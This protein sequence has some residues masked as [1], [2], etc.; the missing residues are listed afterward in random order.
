MAGKPTSVQTNVTGGE[1]SPLAMGRFDLAKFPNSVKILENFLIY[2][3]GGGM[4]RPGTKYVAP[5]KYGD[6]RRTRLIKFQYSVLQNYAMEVGHEYIRF[7]SNG[8][9]VVLT[10]ADVT[11]WG[12]TTGYV[13]GDYVKE[14]GVIYYCISAHTSGTFATDLAANKWVAQSILEIPTPYTEDDIYLLQVAQHQDVMY[15]THPT[16]KVRKLTRN[17]A[18]DFALVEA[19]IV[20]GPFLDDNV[21]ATTIT[22]SSA[23]GATT[24]TASTS[25]FTAN[26]VGSFFRVKDGVVLITAYSSGTSVDGTVQAEPDGTAGNLGSTS[27]E[28]DWAEGAFSEKRG[29]PVTLAFHEQRMY[30][31]SEQYFYGSVIGQ[32][33]NFKE[34]ADDPSASVKFLIVAD[35]ANPI[36]WLASIAKSL[37]NGT[38]GGTFSASSGTANS[39]ITA[40][41]INA[42]QDTNYGVLPIKPAKIS[43]YL[44]YMQR[45][46]YQLRELVYDLLTDR[47]KAND[48]NLL[49]DHILRD[50]GGATDIKHQQSPNDRLWIPREDGQMAVLTRNPEQEV[51][52][53]SRI[54]AG[55]SS[56]VP[57]EFESV[58][59]L[60]ADRVDDV[61]WVIVRRKINGSWTKFVEYFTPE[62]FDDDFDAVHVDSSLTYDNP[63]NIT[64]ITLGASVTIGIVGH[65]LSNGAQ[66]RIDNILGRRPATGSGQTNVT[67]LNRKLFLVKNATADTF[68]LSDTS[69]GNISGTLYTAYL[70]GGEVREMITAV[71]GL[72]HLNGET[73]TVAVDGGLPSAQQTYEVV[74][75]AITLSQKA[76]VIHVGLPYTGTMQMLKLSDGAVPTGQMTKRRLHMSKFRV[77][78]SLGIKIGVSEETLGTV[79]FNK[80]NDP[81]G[82]P[83]ALVTGDVKKFFSGGWSEDDEVIIRQDQPLPLF[84]LAIVLKSEVE[85]S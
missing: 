69:G 38:A 34:D 42:N 81:L 30:Y 70:E 29:Y 18:I 72:D 15:I 35:E 85:E 74:A 45:N 19:P 11:A 14:A 3:L 55:E 22:A 10:L 21:T 51:L 65:G 62:K 61:V 41:D 47:S 43:S 5:T 20:R 12:T 64:S 4:F 8:A 73:V 53:W 63:L 37:Q 66:I 58:E 9:Q 6:L 68:Q 13:V 82:V 39:A 32:F 67:D 48:M 44:Y 50:G 56:G 2:Q 76:A 36:R 7:F 71:T 54:V 83:P 16:K 1:I 60:A 25:I 46:S 31:A 27:A 52:G 59:V 40:D 80:P 75:G 79:F 28:K 33:D 24:L 57:G 23:T 84:I 49:A 77:Y 26:Q 17:S 78:R